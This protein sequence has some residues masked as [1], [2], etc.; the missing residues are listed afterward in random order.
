MNLARGK[1]DG[2]APQS[3]MRKVC[4]V[5][6][7]VFI[8][9]RP[10]HAATSTADAPA[11]SATSWRALSF[12]NDQSALVMR[13]GRARGFRVVAAPSWAAKMG[14]RLAVHPARFLIPILIKK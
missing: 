13:G 10:H 9:S 8:R 11:I 3:R 14:R 1:C 2:R 5:R 12:S 7:A 4:V 6:Y